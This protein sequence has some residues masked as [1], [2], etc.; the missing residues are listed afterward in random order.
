MFDSGVAH[1]IQGPNIDRPFNALTLTPDIHHWFGNFDI[2][3]EPVVSQP[4]TYRIDSFLEPQLA[5]DDFPVTRTLYLTDNH[6]IDPP[7]PRLLALHSAIAHI[8][9][10]SAAGDYIDKLLRDMERAEELGAQTDGSTDLGRLV[11]LR[12]WLEGGV[13]AY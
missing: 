9:H 12:M 10:L 1:I 4:G 2:F 5:G 8:L 6:T 13:D 7:L 3:F 11:Y